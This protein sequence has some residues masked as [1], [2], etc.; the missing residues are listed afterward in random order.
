M[1]LDS[2][3][4][5]TP[6][7]VKI[8]KHIGG[9]IIPGAIEKRFHSGGAR[10]VAQRVNVGSGNARLRGFDE[11]QPRDRLPRSAAGVVLQFGDRFFFWVAFAHGG[12]VAKAL[13]EDTDVEVALANVTGA[14]RYNAFFTGAKARLDDAELGDRL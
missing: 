8:L 5:F 4:Q 13:T 7:F 6:Q 11:H 2:D 14:R 3:A 1:V 12:H 9:L 10:F